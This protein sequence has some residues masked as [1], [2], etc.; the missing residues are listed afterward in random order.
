MPTANA[1]SSEVLD[2]PRSSYSCMQSTDETLLKIACGAVVMHILCA[3]AIQWPD[4][5]REKKEGLSVH[6]G[7]P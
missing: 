1:V 2:T 3:I 5:K 7:V 4:S 6:K